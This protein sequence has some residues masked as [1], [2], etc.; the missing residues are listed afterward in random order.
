MVQSWF[1]DF[2]VVVCSFVKFPGHGNVT[3]GGIVFQNPLKYWKLFFIKKF[4]G[5]V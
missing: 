4:I 1:V 3:G 5:K 2:D